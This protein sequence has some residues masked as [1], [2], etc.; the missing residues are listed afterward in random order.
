LQALSRR[1]ASVGGCW[2]A[3]VG[4]SWRFLSLARDPPRRIL[5]ERR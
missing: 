3:V 1:R 4:G 2:A 5:G